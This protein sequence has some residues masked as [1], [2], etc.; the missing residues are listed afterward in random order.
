[1]FIGPEKFRFT[2]GV[3]LSS[4]GVEQVIQ[5]TKDDVNSI[6]LTAGLA[7]SRLSSY[8]TAEPTLAIDLADNFNQEVFNGFA[9]E[10]TTFVGDA[11]GA[12]VYVCV[13]VCVC[14]V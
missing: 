11:T 7:R 6:R 3:S 2:G 13:C 12:F 9:I 1:M 8:I 5:M 10:C 4:N 14:D